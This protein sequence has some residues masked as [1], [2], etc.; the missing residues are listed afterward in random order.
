MG[1][2]S[3]ATLLSSGFFLRLICHLRKCLL[4]LKQGPVR[5]LFS[6]LFIFMQ[7]K[8]ISQERFRTWNRQLW[9]GPLKTKL[10]YERSRGR[11]LPPSVVNVIE[12]RAPCCLARNLNVRTVSSFF[13]RF[14]LIFTR[15]TKFDYFVFYFLTCIH[16]KTEICQR[17][18]EVQHCAHSFNSAVFH[19]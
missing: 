13:F 5:N 15:Q 8:L 12:V 4:P 11:R 10:R 9:N 17:R 3:A 19:W 6:H 18:L 14:N 1:D 7:L 2:L 16:H